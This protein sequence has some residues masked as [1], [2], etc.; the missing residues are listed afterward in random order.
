MGKKEKKNKGKH[1]TEIGNNK[2]NKGQQVRNERNMKEEG[3]EHETGKCFL[4]LFLSR[5]PFF[6]LPR[7]RFFCSPRVCFFFVPLVVFFIFVP[8]SFFF[9]PACLFFLYRLSFFILSR[10]SFFL[11][12]LCFFLSRR[13]VAYFVPFVFFCPVAFFFVPLPC[14]CRLLNIPEDQD[15]VTKL[16]A[17]LP[18]V[19][20]GLGFRERC[21]HQTSR[22]L[23]KLGRT[24]SP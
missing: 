23:G 3:K 4:S 8:M 5:V 14:M 11:S 19:L 7:C 20:G 18:L 22:L 9:C 21:P 15:A 1:E 13:P 2:G 16:I 6:M 12:R 17:T 24:V 10:M